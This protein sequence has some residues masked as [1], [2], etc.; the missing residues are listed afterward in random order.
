MSKETYA[1][2]RKR[3]LIGLE[4]L[5]WEI[6]PNLK[7]PWAAKWPNRLWFKAQAVYLDEHSLFLDIRGMSIEDFVKE[8]LTT[9]KMRAA[10]VGY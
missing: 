9:A 10:H 6:R 5:G 7:T 4:T 8:V 2:A 1:Q 3:L